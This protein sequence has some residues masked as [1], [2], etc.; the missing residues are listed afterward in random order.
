MKDVREDSVGSD[1]ARGRAAMA[2]AEVDLDGSDAEAGLEDELELVLLPQDDGTEMAGRELGNR[3]AAMPEMR[4]TAAA[5]A[6]AVA[7]G[8]CETLL[9]L[10]LLPPM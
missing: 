4:P 5:A 7:A 1:S 8:K 10:L 2:A 3:A 6:A 9:L